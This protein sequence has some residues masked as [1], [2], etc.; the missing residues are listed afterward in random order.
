MFFLAFLHPFL[1]WLVVP[2]V[3]VLIHAITLNHNP[4][5]VLKGA[6]LVGTLKAAGGIAWFLHSFPISWLGIES[7]EA[8]LLLISFYWLSVSLMIGVGFAIFIF[9]THYFG[10]Q[11]PFAYLLLFPLTFVLAEIFSSLVFSLYSIGPG[12]TLNVGFTFGYVGYAL[13]ASTLPLPLASLGG[14]YALSAGVGGLGVL[15]YLLTWRREWSRLK[16][17]LVVYV[18]LILLI[19]T[20]TQ[21]PDTANHSSNNQKVAAVYTY[22]PADVLV[23]KEGPRIRKQAVSEAV[24]LAATHYPDIIVLPEMAN[25]QSHF[26][27][28]EELL[29]YLS[30]RGDPIVIDSKK[31]TRSNGHSGVSSLIYDSARNTTYTIDKNFLVPQGEYL[32]YLIIGAL[33]LLGQKDFLERYSKEYVYQPGTPADYSSIPD[34]VPSVL[35]CF[36]SVMPNGV[37]KEK[38]GRDTKLLVHPIAHGWF[39]EPHLMWLQLDLMLK[40]QA[41]QNR[42]TIVKAGNMAPEKLYLPDGSTT[43]GLLA[44]GGKY[45]KVFI[46]DVAN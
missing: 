37:A 1:L 25:F 3:A 41:V 12:I 45:W 23:S 8:Q 2:A 14:I 19:V 6:L 46:Y 38:A 10:K 20:V 5:L 39:H 36:S 15:L 29:D 13:A 33:K 9:A 26:P 27:T 17:F 7:A 16:L 21:S 11:Y 32:P 18:L 43:H 30:E 4:L 44:G 42:V 24:E 40:T 22:L 28:S 35:F 31:V 34:N